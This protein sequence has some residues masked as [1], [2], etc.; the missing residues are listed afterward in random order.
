MAF[1]FGGPALAERPVR[2]QSRS[3][4]HEVSSFKMSSH[5][6]MKVAAFESVFPELAQGDRLACELT[7]GEMGLPDGLYELREFYCIEA[8]CDCNSVLV[9]FLRHAGEGREEVANVV[10][11][12][13]EGLCIGE[14]VELKMEMWLDEDSAQGPHA[15]VFV[16]L[17]ERLLHEQPATAER[18]RDRYELVKDGG[19]H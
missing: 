3:H 4:R 15:E 13:R 8:G 10:C 14:S 18:F 6:I 12:W 9:Q 16:R 19:E 1:V 5:G 11:C 2:D 7:D 17:L